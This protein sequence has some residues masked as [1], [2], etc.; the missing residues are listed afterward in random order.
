MNTQLRRMTASAGMPLG[1]AGRR[2]PGVLRPDPWGRGLYR[3]SQTLALPQT[4]GQPL[5]QRQGFTAATPSLLCY[6]LKVGD[7]F[8][9][10]PEAEVDDY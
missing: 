4:G 8:K 2:P 1:K 6:F 10:L 7:V 5:P 9:A 3:A